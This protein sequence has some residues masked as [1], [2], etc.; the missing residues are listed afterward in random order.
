[1]RTGKLP[2]HRLHSFDKQHRKHRWQNVLIP[3]AETEVLMEQALERINAETR[4]V[5]ELG[6]GSGALVISLAL[7]RPGI[8]FI[9][10]DISSG[11]LKVSEENLRLHSVSNVSLRQ[12]HWFEAITEQE[13]FDLIIS[14]PPY[15]NSESMHFLPAEYRAEPRMALAGG[16]DGGDV[17]VFRHVTRQQQRFRAEGGNQFLDV[18]LEAFALIGE[19]QR[20]PG[21]VPG[22]CDGPRDGALVGDA[23]DESDF[24]CE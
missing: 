20:G 24:A 2:S 11:A 4:G 8:Q 7:E 19:C 3:R 16:K 12:G 14:N 13:F 22:L 18:F 1:M 17:L 6:I 5:M 15:V 10:T 23:E 21:L 9:G